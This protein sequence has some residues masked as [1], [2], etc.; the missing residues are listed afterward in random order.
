VKLDDVIPPRMRPMASHQRLGASAISRKSSARPATEIRI[1]GRRPKR[2][3]RDPITGEHRNCI[4]A[5]IATNSPF[6]K[7]IALV[8]PA[9]SSI[10]WG[11]TGMMMP[12]DMTSSRAVTRMKTI[13]AER[14]G[15]DEG[16]M[17]RK[18]LIVSPPRTF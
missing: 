9:S 11:R 15:D 3:D 10:S 17:Q 14:W 1:T 5:H 2:S 8:D 6:H 4:D 12:I 7:P 18:L 16:G 13:A